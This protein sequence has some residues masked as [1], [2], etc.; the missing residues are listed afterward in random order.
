M[1]FGCCAALELYKKVADAGY[2]YIEVP[3]WQLAELSAGDFKRVKEA[4]L[5]GPIPCYGVN[6]YAKVQPKMVGESFDPRKVADYAE[7]VML[8]ASALG[9]K[10]VGIGAPGLRKTPSTYDA[11]KAW[12]QAKS[13]LTITAD[14][15]RKYD[16]TIL[17]ESIHEHACDFC[18]LVDETYEMV[19]ELNLPNVKMVI[20]FYH[21]K[22]MGTDLFDTEKYKDVTA[23]MHISGFG[24]NYSR[25]QLTEKDYDELVRIFKSV[26]WY[27]GTFSNESDNSNFDIEGKKSLDLLKRAYAEANK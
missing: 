24:E 13:F 3:G 27:D 16:I 19:K 5:N 6:S 26:S 23:H 14:V 8:R 21:L 9:A 2:E 18:T 7:F 20:D 4:V 25:P 12:E 15:A 11:K 1:K 10:T 17:F 22:A